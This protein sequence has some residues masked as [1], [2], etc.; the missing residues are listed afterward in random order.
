[1][2]KEEYNHNNE[3][4]NLIKECFNSKKIDIYNLKKVNINNNKADINHNK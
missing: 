4:N 3:D 2:S 1:M